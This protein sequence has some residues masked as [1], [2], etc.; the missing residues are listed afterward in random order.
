MKFAMLDI[1]TV[2]SQIL[3]NFELLPKGEE[4]LISFE[5]VSRAINGMQMAL[6]PRTY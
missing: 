5:I 4:P 2:V 3:R 1:K 6:A